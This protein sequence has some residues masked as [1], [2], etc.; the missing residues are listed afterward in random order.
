[1]S[2]LG[3]EFPKPHTHCP[4]AIVLLLMRDL[5]F[6]FSLKSTTII[7]YMYKQCFNPVHLLVSSYDMRDDGSPQYPIFIFID[8]IFLGEVE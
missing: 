1:M 5:G 4:T 2:T 6:L 3:E 7:L 8:L